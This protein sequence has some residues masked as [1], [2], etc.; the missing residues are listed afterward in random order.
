MSIRIRIWRSKGWWRVKVPLQ[1]HWSIFPLKIGT[2][3]LFLKVRDYFFVLLYFA[4]FYF[5]FVFLFL[6][7]SCYF[8]G[9]DEIIILT[10]QRP[11]IFMRRKMHKK[12]V[13]LMYNPEK[14]KKHTSSYVWKPPIFHFKFTKMV[15]VSEQA[16]FFNILCNV[17]CRTG[18]ILQFYHLRSKTSNN[19]RVYD[20]WIMILPYVYGQSTN[21]SLAWLR[22]KL[23]S[24]NHVFSNLRKIKVIWLLL[25]ML[26]KF[27]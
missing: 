7:F 9:L 25:T 27:W 5:I 19:Y 23:R 24:H 18:I 15:M 16:Q 13:T 26:L 12:M 8:H 20:G 4:L 17:L 14:S 11:I 3:T 21:L 2:R 22:I 10:S 6:I 1:T